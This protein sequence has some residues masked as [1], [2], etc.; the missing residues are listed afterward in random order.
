MS[1]CIIILGKNGLD[2][3]DIQRLDLK[4]CI[5]VLK[6]FDEIRVIGSF[7]GKLTLDKKYEFQ[8]IEYYLNPFIFRDKEIYNIIDEKFIKE[9]IK[10]WKE[11]YSK[12]IYSTDLE[13]IE[14]MED[15]EKNYKE[16]L[17]DAIVKDI[18]E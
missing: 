6:L 10:I 4:K 5:E 9:I 3:I 16:Y 14:I 11:T 15:I 17:N 18:I 2:I 12:E 13:Q 8:Y 1:K 7:V